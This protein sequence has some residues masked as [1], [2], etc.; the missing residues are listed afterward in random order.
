[1]PVA[2]ALKLEPL[3][4]ATTSDYYSAAATA[5]GSGKLQVATGS[6]SATG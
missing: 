5:S 3:S 1:M 6:A 4:Q 2:L